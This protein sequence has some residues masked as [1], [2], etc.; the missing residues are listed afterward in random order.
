MLTPLY[1]QELDH[2]VASNVQTSSYSSSSIA[3][4]AKREPDASTDLRSSSLSYYTHGTPLV[5]LPKKERYFFK[6][7]TL[8][9]GDHPEFFALYSA[10]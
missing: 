6:P 7:I 5:S 2:S 9:S 4:R 8:V 3:K 1:N 10:T